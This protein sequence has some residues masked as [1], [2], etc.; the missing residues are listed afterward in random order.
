M[1]RRHPILSAIPVDEDTPNPY[2]ARLPFINL[3]R[4]IF[5]AERVKPH[6]PVPG[7]EDSWEDEELDR[8]LENQHNIDF[9]FEYGNLPFW[10]LIIL[11]NPGVEKELPAGQNGVPEGGNESNELNEFTACFVFHHA[12]CDGVSGLAFHNSLQNALDDSSSL[13]SSGEC[14][15]ASNENALL[16]PI[17]ELHSLPINPEPPATTLTKAW[18]GN[19]IHTPCKTRFRSLSISSSASNAFIQACK[20]NDVTVTSAL[21]PLI[22]TALYSILPPTI[23]SL[24]CNIPVSLRRWLP[25]DIVDGAMGNWFDAFQIQFFRSEQNSKDVVN[26]WA[27][28]HKASKA[29][30]NYLNASPSG[31]PYTNIGL[32]KAIPDISMVFSSFLGKDRDTGIEVSNL[33]VF[34]NPTNESVWQ[35]AKVMLSRSA[36]VS[37]SAITIAAA[38]GGNGS[39]TLGFTW[40]EG[41]VGGDI[42]DLVIEGVRKYFQALI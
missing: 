42:V 9:S 7:G 30:T 12:L 28:A 40:Q 10:R 11:Q 34:S 41:V 14:V 36:V 39:M 35:V 22:A 5:F 18:K 1:I 33:G 19:P 21:P 3:E 6:Q 26:I 27:Q 23:E 8:I 4:S 32:L 29:I 15:I 37:G 17:E 20:K 2:F 24:N 16:P 25:Q 38:C 31:G 13:H